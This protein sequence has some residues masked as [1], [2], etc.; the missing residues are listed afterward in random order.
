M[1]RIAARPGFT[2]VETML[3]VGIL[4]IMGGMIVGVLMSSQEARIRQQGIALLEQRATQVLQSVTRRVRRGEAVLYPDAGSTGSILVLQMAV[5]AEHPTIFAN[6]GGNL[7]LIEKTDAQQLLGEPLALTH[8]LFRNVGGRSVAI[9]FD[10]STTIRLPTPQT[11]RR[12]F[13]AT[14][15]LFPDDEPESGGCAVCPAVTCAGHE[16]NWY[17][18]DNDVCSQSGSTIAC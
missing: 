3:F 17:Y 11:Y 10:I 9:S 2:L 6:S 7:L 18:C 4:A 14:V 13:D 8:L 12:H 1:K 15:T 16:Y 5:N